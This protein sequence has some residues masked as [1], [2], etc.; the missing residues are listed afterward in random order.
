MQLS[1]KGNH[2]GRKH[3]NINKQTSA[4]VLIAALEC[5]EDAQNAASD[6]EFPAECGREM[7]QG[8]LE[9]IAQDWSDEQFQRWFDGIEAKYG[10]R[11]PLGISM[12]G[13]YRCVVRII[14]IYDTRLSI[15]LMFV[16]DK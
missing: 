9:D 14:Q 2:A 4:A 16:K 13:L 5:I 12:I 3:C 6:A 10:S 8:C 11:S 15:E 1:G 7:L